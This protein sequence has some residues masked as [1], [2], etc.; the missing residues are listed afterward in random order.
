MGVDV[1]FDGCVHA[2][3]AKSTDDFGGVRDL[4]SAEEE[5]IVVLL[6][7]V[8][9]SLET[10]GGEAYGCCSGEVEPARVEE[11]EE[12][13]LQNLP[14]GQSFCTDTR[15]RLSQDTYLRP[16]LQMLELGICQTSDDGIGDIP[17]T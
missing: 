14:S 15:E 8:V 6:P 10:V 16:H 13:I 2:D 1:D 11:I 17:D 7:A 12:G 3:H 5:F 4:L 9:E